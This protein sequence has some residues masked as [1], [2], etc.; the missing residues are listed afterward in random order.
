MR[1]RFVQVLI[2]PIS[3]RASQLSRGI[4]SLLRPTRTAVTLVGAAG[5]DAVRPRSYLVAENAFL[6]QQILVRE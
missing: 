3:R 1:N 6:R 4:K 5:L 2:S